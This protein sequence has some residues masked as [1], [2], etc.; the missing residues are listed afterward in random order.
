MA[1]LTG[2]LAQLRS[3]RRQAQLQVEKLDEAILVIERLLGQK[4]KRTAGRMG[5]RRVLSPAAKRRI[6]QAQKARWAK[7]RAQKKAAA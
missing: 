1:N 3:E 5:V 2:T 6:S 4:G 7:F